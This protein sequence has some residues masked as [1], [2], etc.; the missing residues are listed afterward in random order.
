MIAHLGLLG[1]MVAVAKKPYPG[2]EAFEAHRV[3]FPRVK[4]YPVIHNTS[5]VVWDDGLPA[6]CLYQSIESTSFVSLWE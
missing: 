5:I 3:D 2:S 1:L 4:T 6:A